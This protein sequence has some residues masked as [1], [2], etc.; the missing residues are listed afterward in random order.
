MSTQNPELHEYQPDPDGITSQD[1][2]FDCSTIFTDDL[3][4]ALPFDLLGHNHQEKEI[5]PP[6]LVYL[7]SRH[8]QLL[9][10][11][12]LYIAKNHQ[13]IALAETE[14]KCQVE[15]AKLE[16]ERA[17]LRLAADCNQGPPCR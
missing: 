1:F 2:D 16:L 14:S 13:Q 10:C 15:L 7:N 6:D 11:Q 5:L 8:E 17:K 4:E 3:S 9:N 12:R